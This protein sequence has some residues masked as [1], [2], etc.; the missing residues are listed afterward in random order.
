[1]STHISAKRKYRVEVYVEHF[2]PILIGELVGWMASLNSSAVEQDVDFVAV[3]DNF[4]DQGGNGVAR[5][6]VGGVDFCFA[7]E[8]LDLFACGLVGF[9]ALGGGGMVRS[10]VGWKGGEW[11]FTWTRRMSAPAS[12]RAMA[13][14]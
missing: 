11:R 9:V 8:R 13:I 14:A 6:E 2:I 1:M 4:F 3:G 12:A 10:V 5:G 7:A